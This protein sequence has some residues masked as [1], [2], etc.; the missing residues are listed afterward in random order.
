MQINLPWSSTKHFYAIIYQY[1]IRSFLGHSGKRGKYS[2]K[3]S[4]LDGSCN[5]INGTIQGGVTE[6]L[7]RC[8][9]ETVMDQTDRWTAGSIE[10]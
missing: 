7:M 3:L 6:L 8:I 1:Q 5:I 2:T 4:S 10:V 9:I